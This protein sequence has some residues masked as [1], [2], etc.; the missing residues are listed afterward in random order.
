[1]K[2]KII[3]LLDFLHPTQL[4]TA[5]NVCDM[6]NSLGVKISIKQTSFFNHGKKRVEKLTSHL[7]HSYNDLLNLTNT[8]QVSKVNTNSTNERDFGAVQPGI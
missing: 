2:G 7:A 4:P 6:L 3:S 8:A 1:M 5:H